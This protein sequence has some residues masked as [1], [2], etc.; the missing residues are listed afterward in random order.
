MVDLRHELVLREVLPEGNTVLEVVLSQ[1]VM[2][3]DHRICVAGLP[4]GYPGDE[5]ASQKDYRQESMGDHS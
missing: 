3:A 4:A 5:E 2:T 1:E